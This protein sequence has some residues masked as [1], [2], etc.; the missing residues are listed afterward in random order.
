MVLATG[1]LKRKSNSGVDPFSPLYA[2][3]EGRY[4]FTSKEAV[5]PFPFNPV[6]N[7]FSTVQY[8]YLYRFRDSSPSS[9]LRLYSA[10]LFDAGYSGTLATSPG[11][12]KD[13][14]FVIALDAEPMLT[15]FVAG[16]SE[17]NPGGVSAANQVLY[18]ESN[19][20][21]TPAGAP[22]FPSE[23]AYQGTFCDA[24]EE[25]RPGLV[26]LTAAAVL[27]RSIALKNH[28]VYHRE[29]ELEPYEAFLEYL[30]GPNCGK[31]LS[32]YGIRVVYKLPLL[33]S[34][35]VA[36]T[37]AFFNLPESLRRAR[38]LLQLNQGGG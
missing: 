7:S 18:E 30:P 11:F 38:A 34:I 28:C 20:F 19:R 14:G 36:K 1:R 22:F 17:P 33:G 29:R 32:C 8:P 6:T 12:K 24:D 25:P 5:G 21:D 13:D 15:T 35:R 10:T 3:Q 23:Q 26:L 31:D 9:N 27:S 37:A 2:F 4:P 16:F